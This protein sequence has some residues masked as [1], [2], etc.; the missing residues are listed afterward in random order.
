MPRLLIYQG[1]A[2]YHSDYNPDSFLGHPQDKIHFY[3]DATTGQ[4]YSHLDIEK[5]LKDMN[6]TNANRTKMAFPLPLPEWLR[7]DRYYDLVKKYLVND[8]AQKY[9]DTNELVALLN[10]HKNGGKNNTRK[11]WTIFSFLVWYEEYFIKR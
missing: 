2:F 9:F 6:A 11:I 10:E 4:A 5:Y 3:V 8:V 1:I 7:E